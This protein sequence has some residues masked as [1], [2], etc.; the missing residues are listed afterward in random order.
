AGTTVPIEAIR[1][2]HALCKSL[3]AL[4]P[5][6]PTIIAHLSHPEATV[7]SLVRIVQHPYEDMVL[8]NAVWTFISLGVDKEPALAGLFV[9]GKF[10]TPG[11][12]VKDNGKG[13]AVEES[14][15]GGKE[16]G[17]KEVEKMKTTNKS[18]TPL[19]DFE[20][21][22]RG[23]ATWFGAQDGVAGDSRG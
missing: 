2:L 20:L 3:S 18:T 4:Q 1:V 14:D 11:E 16:V 10:R 5:P 17:K 19:F 6:S 9:T 22:R 21:P 15:K 8:R 7:A 12:V 23:V 13:K